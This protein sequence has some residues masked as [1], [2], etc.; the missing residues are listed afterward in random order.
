MNRTDPE[1]SQPSPRAGRIAATLLLA[2]IAAGCRATRVYFRPAERSVVETVDRIAGAQFEL[3]DEQ[4]RKGE[5]RVWCLYAVEDADPDDE[6]GPRTYVD[7]GLELE[8]NSKDELQLVVGEARLRDV[9]TDRGRID[10]VAPFE[11]GETVRVAPDSVS[12]NYL[13]FELPPGVRPSDVRTFRLRWVVSGPGQRSF[14]DFTSF[15]RGR[16]RYYRR[17]PHWGW[18][19][20]FGYSLWNWHWYH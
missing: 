2:L 14:T 7:I 12:T 19:F 9:Q 16:R 3:R 8:N 17:G 13:S 11:P 4:G 6:R 18:G 20:L 15:V 5:L 10:S 1:S